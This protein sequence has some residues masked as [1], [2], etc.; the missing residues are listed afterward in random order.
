MTALLPFDQ[1]IQLDQEQHQ[2]LALAA[3]FQA[4]QIV[5]V[6]ATT[7][8]ASLSELKQEH[9]S[10]LLQSALTIRSTDNPNHNSLVFFQSLQQLKLGLRCLEQSLN[11]PYNTQ[12]KSPYPK[13]KVKNTK[14]TLTYTMA[15]LH[16][17]AKVYANKDY[18]EKITKAQQDI[19]RQ[20][21]FFNN[22]YHHPSIIS[23]LAQVY[24]DT[25][26][27][28]KPRIM[29]KGSEQAFKSAHEVAHIR[30]ML[31]TG[32]QAAH[33]WRNLGGS[34]WKLIFSK[35]KILKQIQNLAKLQL[36]QQPVEANSH[37]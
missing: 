16:L 15:L 8:T 19:V 31:F 21:T 27:T 22:D 33:Y 34:P 11:A 3:V 28:M 2:I 17:S 26:S 13:L 6:I 37:T 29:V 24:S 7:G 20:L 18:Q 25:A 10:I 14:Q 5:H 32:L 4:A 9:I 35:G 36:V 12:P 1:N 23:A 30:A